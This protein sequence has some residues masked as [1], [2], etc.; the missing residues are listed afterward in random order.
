MIKE[1]IND[2]NARMRERDVL[3]AEIVEIE[4]QATLA[5]NELKTKQDTLAR[6]EKDI[7][8]KSIQV[9]EVNKLLA[10]RVELESIVEK[11][12]LE[13][14]ELRD[15]QRELKKRNTAL[16]SIITDQQSEIA[17]L[18]ASCTAYMKNVASYTNELN[19]KRKELS[20]LET[21]FDIKQ[22]EELEKMNKEKESLATE[23][24]ELARIRKDCDLKIEKIYYASKDMPRYINGIQKQF[25][26]LGIKV[27]FKKMLDKVV[28]ST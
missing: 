24:Q 13:V 28:Q 2:F 6:L 25:D 4:K 5:G 19:K 17:A 23:R 12:R 15:E 26:D 7:A 27:P 20:Q 1:L 3:E 9:D 22:Q 11:M 10:S 18:T 16:M 21:A 14:S 8:D